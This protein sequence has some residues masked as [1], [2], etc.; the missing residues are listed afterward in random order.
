MPKT[1]HMRTTLVQ[2][3]FLEANFFSTHIIQYNTDSIED[4]EKKFSLNVITH[5]PCTNNVV[6]KMQRQVAFFYST[7]Q[8]CLMNLAKA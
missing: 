1:F 3:S 7:L 6:P 2:D 8:P 5:K 4:D